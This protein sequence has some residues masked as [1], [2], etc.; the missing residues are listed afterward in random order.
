MLEL[1]S[2]HES[3]MI[4]VD[5]WLFFYVHYCYISYLKIVGIFLGLVCFLTP[6]F[7]EYSNNIRY[8]H[9]NYL[10]SVNK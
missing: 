2:A 4:Y 3:N 10:S 8:Q 5:C 9:K 7:A 6:Y 1:D